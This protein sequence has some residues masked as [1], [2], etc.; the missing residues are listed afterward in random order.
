MKAKTIEEFLGTLQQS[1]VETW[2]EHLKT[3]KYSAHIA[4][5]DFYEDIV[6][7]VDSLIEEYQGKYGVVKDLKNIMTS[8]K[9]GAIKYLEELHELAASGRAEL[10]DEKDSEL[11]SDIDAILSLIDS[12]L[13]KLKELK[14][15]KV[16]L[17]DFLI[18]GLMKRQLNE[19][20]TGWK[21]AGSGNISKGVDVLDFIYK[22]NKKFGF[23]T[24]LADSETVQLVAADG[25]QEFA[26]AYSIDDISYCEDMFKLKVGG[27]IDENSLGVEYTMRIW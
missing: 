18:E 21:P 14:E 27:V 15:K 5:N 6:E 4:L 23:L 3:D 7:L 9:L 24:W 8:E 12:T 19:A 10:I 2:K 1:T 22:G 16:D 17:K 13:Y 25:P 11:Q 26:E 20:S